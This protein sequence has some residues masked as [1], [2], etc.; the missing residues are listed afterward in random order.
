MMSRREKRGH[1]LFMVISERNLEAFKKLLKTDIDLEVRDVY[2]DTPLR[3]ALGRGVIEYARLLIE[4]GAEVNV[5]RRDCDEYVAHLLSQHKKQNESIMLLR[6]MRARGCDL[7]VKDKNGNTPLHWAIMWRRYELARV[8]LEY[9]AD[10]DVKNAASRTPYDYLNAK[11][12]PE[13]AKDLLQAMN[14]GLRL[15]IERLER[16]KIEREQKER[17]RTDAE[18]VIETQ[19]SDHLLQ[20]VFNFATGSYVSCMCNS[21]TKRVEAFERGEIWQFKDRT[22]LK[23]AFNIYRDR[24]PRADDRIL[25]QP[26]S[27]AQDKKQSQPFALKKD[28]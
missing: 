16:E 19:V 26:L 27:H 20:D 17:D 14:P 1:K 11:K 7:A 23:K 3:D 9:G 6:L 22:I 18:V 15:K 5:A 13:V 10:P 8:L 4:A 24:N 28:C 25:Y 2:G 21:E 12:C